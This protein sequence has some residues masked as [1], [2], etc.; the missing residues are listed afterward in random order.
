[1]RTSR[2][3]LPYVPSLGHTRAGGTR[4]SALRGFSRAQAEVRPRRALPERLVSLLQ[5]DV[6][7]RVAQAARGVREAIVPSVNR[8]ALITGASSGIGRALARLFAGDG[9]ELVLVARSEAALTRVA[10]ELS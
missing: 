8:I 7:R 4:L 1:A 2:Q 6:R 10:D 9:Y 5:N 3:L